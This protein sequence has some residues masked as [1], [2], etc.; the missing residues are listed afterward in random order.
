[1][2]TKTPGRALIKDFILFICLGIITWAVNMFIQ[3]VF[4]GNNLLPL[5]TRSVILILVLVICYYLNYRFTRKNQ[6]NLNI[7]KFKTGLIKYCFAAVILGCLLIAAMWPIIYLLY[8][9]SIIRN[10]N[11][12]IVPAID[13]VTYSLG[14]TLEE[15][16]FRGFLLLAAVK[17]FRK[18]GAIL[19]VS[20]LFALFHLPGTG[21]S[22][23]GLSMMIT[24]FTMSLLFIAVIYY[25]ASVWTAVTLHITGNFL[26]HTLGFD[27]ANNG[28]FQVK[29]IATDINSIVFTLIYEIVVIAFAMVIFIKGKKQ[30]LN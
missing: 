3:T 30:L 16:L 26:L 21:L 15:L 12:A 4:P 25:T 29:F 18:T 27:G 28:L 9:F 10:H 8:P 22:W 20:F 7:L 6:L 13:L 1:M 19:L 5:L 11:T 14:N 2:N 17:L 24:T 23:Q